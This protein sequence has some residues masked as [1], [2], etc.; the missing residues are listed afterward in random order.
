MPKVLWYPKLVKKQKAPLGNFSVTWDK[1][2][3]K[4]RDT[5]FI[6]KIFDTSTILKKTEGFNYE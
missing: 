3:Q 1:K 4:N 2:V 6:Q 5:H